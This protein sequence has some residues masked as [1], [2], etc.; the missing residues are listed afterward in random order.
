MDSPAVSL[1][2]A[3]AR[4]LDAFQ[5]NSRLDHAHDQIRQVLRQILR[6]RNYDEAR[7]RLLEVNLFGSLS[8]WME[9]VLDERLAGRNAVPDF[10]RHLQR[11]FLSHCRQ[12]QIEPE[13]A[14]GM[15][16]ELAT[17]IMDLAL[18][19]R[20]HLHLPLDA[21]DEATKAP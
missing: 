1:D 17:S 19:F 3:L 16:V 10:A 4:I 11:A 12:Y 8:G 21:G 20:K 5:T 18:S 15:A 7:L 2:H 13:I 14:V 6:Q 9:F